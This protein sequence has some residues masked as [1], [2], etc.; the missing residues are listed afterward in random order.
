MM[1]PFDRT[2][3]IANSSGMKTG[4]RPKS[5]PMRNKFAIGAM[6]ARARDWSTRHPFG[7][8]K[9]EGP[10]RPM[11]SSAM[12]VR[13]A[14]SSP[15]ICSMLCDRLDTLRGSIVGAFR[16]AANGEPRSTR[17]STMR[18]LLL[19]CC[20]PT[21]VRRGMSRRS[22]YTHRNRVGLQCPCSF[23]SA[24]SPTGCCDSHR[25]SGSTAQTTLCLAL[26]NASISASD[27][28]ESCRPPSRS[29]HHGPA[30][31]A[32]HRR[33]MGD[34]MMYLQRGIDF[35]SRSISH[36]VGQEAVGSTCCS[37]LLRKISSIPKAKASS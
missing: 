34:A 12:H 4:R 5:S 11:S 23:D 15:I 26:F 19:W 28:S 32:G 31:A 27:I 25:G 22:C 33:D 17:S 9:R 7:I 20:L 29:R 21:L 14:S 13:T 2:Q 37:P 3:S 18:W 30:G 8:E 16:A 35:R 10:R 6:P 1:R 24:S 36:L